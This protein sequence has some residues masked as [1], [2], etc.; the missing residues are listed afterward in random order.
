MQKKSVFQVQRA[1]ELE[2]P[3]GTLITTRHQEKLQPGIIVCL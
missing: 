2:V 3:Q 1:K